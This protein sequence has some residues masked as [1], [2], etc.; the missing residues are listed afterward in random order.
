MIKPK[1]EEADRFKEIRTGFNQSD[2]NWT[3]SDLESEEERVGRPDDGTET[4]QLHLEWDDSI[5]M[6]CDEFELG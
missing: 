5:V 2:D 3:D 6:R 4:T 1:F